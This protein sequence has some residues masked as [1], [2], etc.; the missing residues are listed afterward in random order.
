MTL[1]KDCIAPLLCSVTPEDHI[2]NGE[3]R[4]ILGCNEE[5]N[6]YGRLL[7]DAPDYWRLN[8]KWGCFP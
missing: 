6:I 1:C 2:I 8:Q 3:E 7:K 5:S 4:E